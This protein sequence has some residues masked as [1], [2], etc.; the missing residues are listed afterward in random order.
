MRPVAFVG[1]VSALY[2]LTRSRFTL[3]LAINQGFRDLVRQCS[4]V[5]PSHRPSFSLCGSSL[6]PVRL[7]V[8]ASGQHLVW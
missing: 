7:L 1:D 5:D 4:V 8:P 3:F 6:T 2:E